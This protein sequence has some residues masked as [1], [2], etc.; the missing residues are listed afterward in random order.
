MGGVGCIA[1]LGSRSKNPGSQCGRKP[2]EGNYCGLHMKTT[3]TPV[4]DPVK[5]MVPLEVATKK[6]VTTQDKK[7]FW[8]QEFKTY[9]QTIGGLDGWVLKFDR[10]KRRLGLCRYTKKTIQL[11]EIMV[12]GDS[13]ENIRNTLLHEIA[14]ALVGSERKGGKHIHHGPKWVEKAKE[15]GCNGKRCGRI[16]TAPEYKYI[17]KCDCGEIKFLKKGR[18]D[19]TKRYCLTCKKTF[20][21]I[22]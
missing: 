5:K 14:H 10:A 21:Q 4:N 13:D 7:S 18:R 16:E 9:Q 8:L 19:Y 22:K 17:Y 11:S 1:I 3:A 12:T 2:K 20:I 6:T 15:I